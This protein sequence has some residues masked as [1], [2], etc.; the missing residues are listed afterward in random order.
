[1]PGYAVVPGAAG[2]IASLDLD[3]HCCAPN[4][5]V[6]NIAAF[7]GG[8]NAVPKGMVLQRDIDAAA[9]P[10]IT[11]LQQNTESAMQAQVTPSER[12]VDQSMVCTPATT[13]SVPAN[14]PAKTVTVH[15]QVTCHA[16][17]YNAAGAQAMTTTLLQEKAQHDPALT[18]AYALQGQIL[19]SVLS[20]TVVTRE[21]QVS[22]EIQAQG[23]WV[24]QLTRQMQQRMTQALVA[25]P[26][27]QALRLLE[28]QPGVAAATISISSGTL[29]PA[30]AGDITL[31][32]QALPGVQAPPTATPGS[33]PSVQPTGSTPTPTTG[34]GLGGS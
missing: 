15:V 23:I 29:M 9:H 7:T 2:N 17:V 11:S 30:N 21:G 5:N 18:P 19:S 27:E 10:L 20:E 16:E 34:T 14:T 28:R 26:K 13:S 24:Y 22:L 4:V 1:V 25:L 8:Q 3:G 33:R 32:I 12:L 6:K 31:V